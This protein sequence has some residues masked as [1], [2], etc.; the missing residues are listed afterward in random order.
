MGLV[1]GPQP[2]NSQSIELV[3]STHGRILIGL[4][5]DAR[6]LT[7]KEKHK[8]A[9]SGLKDLL[10]GSIWLLKANYSRL[11]EKMDKEER[12]HADANFDLDLSCYLYDDK[13]EVVGLVAPDAWHAITET[14]HVYHS[15]EDMDG[16]G[17][18]DDEQ[19]YIHTNGLP[20]NIR[21]V[22]V[23][24]QSDCAHSLKNVLNP[25]IHVTDS[26]ADKA[27][28][29]V[30]IDKLPDNDKYAFVFCRLH[31][32]ESNKW[33]MTNISHFTDFDQDWP[34]YLKQFRK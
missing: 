16:I 22:F 14:G 4:S 31:R 12:D 25:A 32:D 7:D 34:E 27:L 11:M 9:L 10:S 1:V 2:G 28:L 18:P 3:P 24:V 15:G 17:G 6:D 29:K 21:D 26:K 8:V 23:V 30:Q 20:E 5:W 19:V 33:R 13:G